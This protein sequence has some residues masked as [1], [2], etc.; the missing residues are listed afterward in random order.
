M[1][2][3]TRRCAR[4]RRETRCRPTS[5]GSGFWRPAPLTCLFTGPPGAELR[6]I[7]AMTILRQLTILRQE[8]KARPTMA[9]VEE[10]EGGEVLSPLPS[11]HAAYPERRPLRRLVLLAAAGGL[12]LAGVAFLP[13][14]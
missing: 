13:A 7:A 1:S 14:L 10:I 3:S 11:T 9:T 4:S 2:R 6:R 8:G 5:R 12:V